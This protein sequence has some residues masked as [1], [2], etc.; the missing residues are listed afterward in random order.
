MKL[1]WLGHS[2]FLLESGG[3]RALLDPYKSVQ[4]LADIAME[5]DAV[6]CSHGHSGSD[7]RIF[8]K[9]TGCFTEDQSAEHSRLSCKDQ[10]Y[11]Q[12]L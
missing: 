5:A 7:S 10:G 3:F 8:W 6:Y 4:G 11:M 2:C 1:T 9:K 12:R